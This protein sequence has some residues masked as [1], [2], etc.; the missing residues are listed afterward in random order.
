MT[1]PYGFMLLYFCCPIFLRL[2]EP[3]KWCKLVCGSL[4]VMS[5]KF[6][7]HEIQPVAHA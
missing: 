5:V 7:Y 1:T 3:E 4:V 6:G 2:Q